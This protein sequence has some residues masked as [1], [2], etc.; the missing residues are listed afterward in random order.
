M[1]PSACGPLQLHTKNGTL[2]FYG[3]MQHT[4]ST[5]P[6]TSEYWPPLPNI[7]FSCRP[8]SP[9]D[10]PRPSRSIRLVQSDFPVEMTACCAY[11]AMEPF[12]FFSRSMSRP[13]GVS[14]HAHVGDGHVDTIGN[15]G[16]MGWMRD[17]SEEIR[18]MGKVLVLLLALAISL[19]R[20]IARD[21]AICRN[22]VSSKETCC[23]NNWNLSTCEAATKMERPLSVSCGSPTLKRK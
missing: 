4:K 9:Q 8:N 23:I 1:Q 16:G 13:A 10:V 17:A 12:R 15:G 7:A 20:S 5:Y 22:G 14:A 6:H 19:T 3:P 2:S 18:L 21:Q 11:D